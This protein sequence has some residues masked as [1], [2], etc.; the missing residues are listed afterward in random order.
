[1][2][3]RRQES[4]SPRR[5]LRT[6]GLA[7]G[8]NRND[9][10]AR[11]VPD[12]RIKRHQKGPRSL[13]CPTEELGVPIVICTARLAAAAR[14]LDRE[15]GCRSIAHIALFGGPSSRSMKTSTLP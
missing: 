12:A 6:T 1:M 7:S 5:G 2:P 10:R 15:S 4:S 14:C 8:F 11:A 3:T 9:G 13:V